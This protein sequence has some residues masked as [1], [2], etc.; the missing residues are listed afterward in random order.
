MRG[1]R[2]LCWPRWAAAGRAPAEL[3]APGGPGRPEPPA[4]PDARHERADRARAARPRRSPARPTTA[5]ARYV[6]VLYT[7]Q[8]VRRAHIELADD[9]GARAT[10]RPGSSSGCA[11]SAR[12]AAR[13]ARSPATP[14]PSSSRTS[15]ASASA[16]R[17]CARSP[18]RRSQL[19]DGLCN[20]T[21]VA[22][23]N[24]GW[25]QTVF[26]EPDVERLWD[27]VGQAVRLDQPD[28]VA[29]WQEHIERLAAARRVAQRAPV[30]SPSLPRA[31]HRPDDRAASRRRLAGGARRVARHQARRE[32]A[33]R[34][35]VHDA[36]RASRRGHRALD[37][38]AADPGQHRARPRGALREAAARS[39]CMPPPA[40]T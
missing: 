1:G 5:G 16:R 14:S 6:D 38:A 15:T 21:I 26:G 7:D 32:H 37:A 9:D 8:H 36:R 24:E 39:R 29:A 35:G 2:K 22:Y 25:A 3:R 27:A 19:T 18:R 33:D 28:P 30:R 31:R 4:G 10:R 20:W 23:P 17:A 12:S 34:R 40:R 11:S 13:S